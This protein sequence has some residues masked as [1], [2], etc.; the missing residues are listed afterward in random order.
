[1]EQKEIRYKGSRIMYRVKGSGMPVVLVHGFGE[2]G[3]IW[4]NQYDAFPDYKL[5]IPDLPGSGASEMIDDMSM[6][7]M[8]AVLEKLIVHESA[9]VFYKEGEPGSVV[10]IGHSMGG[11]ISLAFAEKHPEMLSGLGLF[12]SSAYADS[13]EKK[14]TR[15]KGIAF[16]KEH[17]AFAFLKTATPNLYSPATKETAPEKVDEHVASLHNFSAEVIVKYYEA[18]MARPDRTNVLKSTGLP[19]LFIFGRL[20]TVIPLEDGL[21]QSHLPQLSYIHLLEHSGH[22]GMIEE[23]ELANQHLSEYLDSVKRDH[24]S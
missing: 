22:M 7:G 10:M 17:G 4:K 11:Y 19:V 24:T 12:H 21:Q 23:A 2:D 3:G 14:E 5:I 18:M 8:A 16:T 13:E 6:E 15:K 1:M 9:A 20:D